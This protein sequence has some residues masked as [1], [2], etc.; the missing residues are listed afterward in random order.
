MICRMTGRIVTVTEL[1]AIIETAGGLCYEVLV[2]RSAVADLTQRNGSEAT[3][4]TFQY[5]EG[6]PAGSNFIPRLLGFPSESER[7]FFTEFT[8]VKG[9][10]MRKALRA[11]ALPAHQIATAIERGDERTLTGLPEIGKK[12]AAQICTDLRG[13]LERFLTADAGPPPTA[14]TISAPQRVAIDILVSW[15][16]RRGDAERLVAA[17]VDSDAGLKSPEEIVR[18]AYRL[19]QSSGA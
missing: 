7:D 13:K 5:I 19:K 3:L 2:P 8:K 14:R 6:N 18:A 12:L 15:G 1:A 16:D 4:F 9:V 11:M 17:A 10:G